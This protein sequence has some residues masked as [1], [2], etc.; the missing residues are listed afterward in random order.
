[1]AAAPSPIEVEGSRQAHVTAAVGGSPPD[2]AIQRDACARGTAL[3]R[4][5]HAAIAIEVVHAEERAWRVRA[6]RTAPTT[7][8]V[9]V[10]SSEARTP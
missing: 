4:G 5:G 9:Y 3:P 10:H 2:V 6:Y 1:M 8:V 7:P